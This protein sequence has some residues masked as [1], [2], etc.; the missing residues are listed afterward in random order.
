MIVNTE[1]LLGNAKKAVELCAADGIRVWGVTKGLAGDPRLAEVYRA[2]CFSGISDSR[3]R[4]LKKI[5]DA[6]VALPRQLMRVAMRSELEELAATAD[7]SLQSEVS[8]IF[9]LDEIC[10][11]LGV[12]HEALLMMD[13]GDLREGFWPDEIP[14]TARKLKELRGG[15]KLNGVAANF[16]CASGVLPTRKNMEDLVRYRDG[17]SEILG[18]ELPVISVGGTCCLKIIERHEAP[19][20]INQLRV[21]EGVLL[22]Y[23]T[24][25]DRP[26]PYMSG[27]AITIA[28]EIVECRFKPSVPVGETGFQAFGEKPAFVDRGKRK[29]A[30]LG[31]GRQDVNIDKISPIEPGV[32]IVTASSDHLIADVTDAGEDEIPGGLKPGGALSFRPR[33]PAM[34]ACATSEYVS[35]VFE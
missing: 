29:R 11:R 4:N 32:S 15:V 21:C 24:A 25:F 2:A 27:D 9:A 30:L 8:T 17:F 33:Y 26:L 14:E 19:R 28:A 23:D 5:K 34:L 1:K 20:G 35:V 22:G 3:L 18:R 16:A 13:I 31:I 10:A 12:T 7:V 6:G